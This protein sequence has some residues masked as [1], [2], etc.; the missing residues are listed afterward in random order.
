VALLAPDPR[1]IADPPEGRPADD[2]APDD[3]AGGTPEPLR[4]DLYGLLGRDRVL[5]R[6]SELIA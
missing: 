1:R 3:V 2:R 4:R 6:A 5:A